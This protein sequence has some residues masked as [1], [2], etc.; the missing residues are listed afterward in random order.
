M[1]FRNF[2]EL[3]DVASEHSKV[4]EFFQFVDK[5]HL[6]TDCDKEECDL[7]TYVGCLKGVLLNP[8]K[9]YENKRSFFTSHSINYANV[10]RSMFNLKKN[11]E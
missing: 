7:S 2:K 8:E 3:I 9:S 10:F 5:I 6:L 4:I 11:E 1:D